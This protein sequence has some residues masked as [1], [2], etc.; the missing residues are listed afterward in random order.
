M[1]AR[2]SVFR[3]VSAADGLLASAAGTVTSAACPATHRLALPLQCLGTWC[4]E[5]CPQV[6]MVVTLCLR[7]LP[8]M[9]HKDKAA[10]VGAV[11]QAVFPK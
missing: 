11:H 7:A 3:P 4:L 6:A 2:S 1:A 5:R 8:G 9:W 10:G